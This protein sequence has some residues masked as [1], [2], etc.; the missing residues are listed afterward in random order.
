MKICWDNLVGVVMTESGIFIKNKT[1]YLIY[2]DSCKKCGE[3]YLTYKYN[4]SIFCGQSCAMSGRKFSEEHRKKM[5]DKNGMSKGG[6]WK[7]KLP[8]FDT[9]AHQ[10]EYAEHVDYTI[11]D[12]GRKLLLVRCSKCNELFV[13]GT[14][15][16]QSRIRALKGEI[17]GECRFYCSDMCR[18][19][20]E[21]FGKFP[22]SFIDYNKNIEHSYT[23]SE[24]R[25]W[26]KEVLKRHNYICEYCGK[27]ANSAHHIIPKKLDQFYALD[28]DNGIACC[29]NCHYKYGHKDEC[30]TRRL[31]VLYCSEG[32]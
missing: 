1:T 12:E 15:Y 25:V 20:C 27:K 28:P 17:Y 19:R 21:V 22:K 10:I 16:V 5:S 9:Y 14:Y 31:A 6:V 4:K 30:S 8:L 29:D 13:P 3:E 11:D 24:L 26:S 23:E 18:S 7:L 2:M 32:D